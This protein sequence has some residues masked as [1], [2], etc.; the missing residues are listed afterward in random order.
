MNNDIFVVDTMAFVLHLEKRKMPSKAKEIFEKAELNACKIL[1]PSMVLAEIAY[2]SEKNR[3]ETNLEEVE[4]Y[5]QKFPNITI[6]LIDLKLTQKAFEISDIPELHDRL[7][8]GAAY[9]F[10]FQIVTNDPKMENST[11]VNTLWN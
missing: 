9:Y 11:F 6:I 7:I 2:L 4:K 8:A 10:D 5:L 3:I 1:I